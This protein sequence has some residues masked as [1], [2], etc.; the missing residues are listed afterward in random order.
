MKIK[1]CIAGATGWIGKALSSAVAAEE[2]LE[3]VS[4]ISRGA[5]GQNL[6]GI[7]QSQKINL[8]ISGSVEDALAASPD[9]LVDYTKPDAVKHHALTAISRGV[10]VVI[11]TSGL[12]DA[13]YDEIH[14]AAEAQNVGVLAAGNF[15]ITAVLLMRFAEIA[16][17]YV[18]HWEVIDYAGA[19][20]KDA[21]SGTVRELAF[22]LSQVGPPETVHPVSETLGV[23]ETRGATIGGTQVHS[24]LSLI[25][26]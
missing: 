16:A 19:G 17:K 12:A 25:H 24:L 3:L 18:P 8:T 4:A 10:H 11:G 9:V 2:D 26:I 5:A 1:V 21:P 23:K 13:D 15:A 7:L 6:G 14:N 22:R 20:K